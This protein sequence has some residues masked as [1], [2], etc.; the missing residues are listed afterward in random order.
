MSHIVQYLVRPVSEVIE[1]SQMGWFGNVQTMGN[2]WV[3]TDFQGNCIRQDIWIRDPEAGLG[4]Q[5]R[6]KED[7]TK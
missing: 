7:M 2:Q 1:K 4:R 6:V 3:T 5:R